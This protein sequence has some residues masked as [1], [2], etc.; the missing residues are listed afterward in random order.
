MV[1]L[2]LA[3]VICFAERRLRQ[4]RQVAMSSDPE[5]KLPSQHR[6]ARRTGVRDGSKSDTS[7]L[8]EAAAPE[9]SQRC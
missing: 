1:F 3:T 5:S 8:N 4:R 7:F 6:H 9:I 2:P